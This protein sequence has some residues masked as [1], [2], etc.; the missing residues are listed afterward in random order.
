M[1]LLTRLNYPWGNRHSAQTP[2]SNKSLA[3]TATEELAM[4]TSCLYFQHQTL[5]K[6]NF[7]AA[8]GNAYPSPPKFP[9]NKKGLEAICHYPI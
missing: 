5:E 4:A 1:S 9:D 3:L 2:T 7:Y 6:G 8:R